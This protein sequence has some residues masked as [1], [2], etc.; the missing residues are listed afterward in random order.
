MLDNNDKAV[1]VFVDEQTDLSSWLK[2]KPPTYNFDLTM[3]GVS[4][5]VYNWAVGL[6]DTTKDN[7]IGL[8]M[9]VTKN[10]TDSGWV[11][12]LQVTVK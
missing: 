8:Q 1:K 3:K 4:V 12:L 7:E 6:V 2:G 5:G 11:R 9:A 10:L